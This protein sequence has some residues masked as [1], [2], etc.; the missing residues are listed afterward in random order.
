MKLALIVAGWWLIF[1]VAA[2]FPPPGMDDVNPDV[3]FL[4]IG[5]LLWFLFGALTAKRRSP[6][7]K[8]DPPHYEDA[9]RFSRVVLMALLSLQLPMLWSLLNLLISG[10]Q[11][12]ELRASVFG[13]SE[14]TSMQRLVFGW[15]SAVFF[16]YLILCSFSYSLIYGKSKYLIFSIVY[17]V[18]ASVLKGGRG[19]IY[20]FSLLLTIFLGA[21][22]SYRVNLLGAKNLRAYLVLALL[23]FGVVLFLVFMTLSRST[24]PLLSDILIYHTVGFILFSK[25]ITGATCGLDIPSYS[26]TSFLIGLQYLVE[27]MNNFMLDID[28]QTLSSAI[29]S[30]QDRGLSVS[31]FVSEVLDRDFYSIQYYNAFYT[32]LASGYLSFGIYGVYVL[33]F[34]LGYIVRFLS[35]GAA[36]RDF[37]AT[38]YLVLAVSASKMGIF[39]S[40]FESVSLYFVLGLLNIKFLY[41]RFFCMRKG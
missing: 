3:I 17:I 20:Q 23:F 15:S 7:K 5:F 11:I 30:C 9:L 39:G 4:S 28:V 26:P 41:L 36:C 34:S 40:P 27:L 6:I 19:E 37:F 22:S 31:T 33:G 13:G 1:T 10:A 24:S 21:Y 29:L 38:N 12:S 16:N 8:I 25:F 32:V 14:F 2:F 18:A 35:D